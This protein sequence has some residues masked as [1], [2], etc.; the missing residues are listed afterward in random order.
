MVSFSLRG[1]FEPANRLVSSLDLFTHAVSLGGVDSL[2]QLPA[3]LTHRPVAPE[4]RPAAN[5]V[6]LSVGL[7]D[8]EDLVDDLEAGLRMRG[9]TRRTDLS[10]RIA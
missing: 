10:S 5:L 1:G 9:A 7:E 8:I 6:R 2:I 4:A 3:A